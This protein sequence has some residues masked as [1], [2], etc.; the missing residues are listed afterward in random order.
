MGARKLVKYYND[1][2][3]GSL[4]PEQCQKL[5]MLLDLDSRNGCIE[6]LSGIIKDMP[7]ESVERFIEEH[8]TWGRS[9]GDYVWEDG[10]LSGY[11]TIAVSFMYHAGRCIL[12]DSVG[13]GKTVEVAG[14][15][16]LFKQENPSH[17]YLVLTE[18]NAAHQFRSE[19]VRFTGEFVT[20]VPSGEADVL[21]RFMQ[22]NP[23]DSRVDYSVVGTHALLTAGRFL[24][25]LQLV[26]CSSPYGFPFDTLIIDESSVLGNQNTNISKSFA[27]LSKYFKHVYF[28]NATP[29]ESQLGVFFSQLNMLDPELLPTKTNF[30][31]EYC[32]LDHTGMYPRQTGRYKNQA[33]FKRLVGYRYLARTR[34]GKGA[35]MES[36]DGGVV[37]SELSKA[38]KVWLN[39]TYLKRMIYDC[40]SYICQ[41]IEFNEENVPKLASLRGLLEGECAEAGTVIVFIQYKEA[42]R[43]VSQW[44]TDHGYS[45]RVLNGDTDVRERNTIIDGFRN[46]DFRVLL[47][48]VQKSL[49][50]GSCDY[51]IFYGYDPNPSRMVQFEGRITRDFNIIGKHVYILCSAGEEYRNL[52]TSIRQRALATTEFTNADMSVVMNILLG[53]DSDEEESD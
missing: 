44:L 48:S 30:T 50:F 47:T 35:I 17:R 18:K 27:M 13:M 46:G 9:Y 34:Q 7:R 36:C 2:Y 40:P 8:E 39:R 24:Q 6:E 19:M 14:V 42:Q 51:C 22:A 16:N 53:G 5:E 38:Q 12:G 32:V 41:D 52:M 33:S 28:L 1:R 4:I 49:N 3:C 29:F 23:Y 45:N 26:R 31:K 20:L 25:W 15:C 10:M 43:H 37:L 11:Q 21:E